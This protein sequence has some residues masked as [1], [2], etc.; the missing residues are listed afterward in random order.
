MVDHTEIRES[1][2]Y[3][4]KN[5]HKLDEKTLKNGKKVKVNRTWT[6]DRENRLFESIF[7]LNYIKHDY[8]PVEVFDNDILFPYVTNVKGTDEF[9]ELFLETMI[10]RELY[11]FIG[12]KKP[13]CGGFFFGK[14]Y[15]VKLLGKADEKA[16]EKA[17]DYF[18]FKIIELIQKY[19]CPIPQRK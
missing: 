5:N 3:M 14:F 9:N 17:D 4:F 12:E 11:M 15:K 10:N 6:F 1:I 19:K 13:G 16:D 2:M 18:K 7:G 8:P